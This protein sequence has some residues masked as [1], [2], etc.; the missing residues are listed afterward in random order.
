MS[1]LR[2]LQRIVHQV[3]LVMLNF[4]DDANATSDQYHE[5]SDT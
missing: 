1:E 2:P 4:E 5:I 3:I